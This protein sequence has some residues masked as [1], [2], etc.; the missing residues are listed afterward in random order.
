MGWFDRFFKKNNTTKSAVSPVAEQQILDLSRLLGFDPAQYDEG[1]LS[2]VT[3]FACLKM[4]SEAIGKLPL[5]LQRVSADGGVED[6]VDDPLYR[7]VK[8][9]PN[10][11][12]TP[13]VFWEATENNCNHYG[14]AYAKIRYTEHGAEL[15]PLVSDR[16]RI[17]IPDG[18]T[19]SEAADIMY[20]YTYPETGETVSFCS[21]EILHFKT[22][23]TFGG[24]LGL[25]VR[26]KLRMSLDG[27]KDSQKVLNEM[28][29]NNMAGRAV[30]QYAGTQEINDAL[31]ERYI[32]ELDDFAHGRKK[33]GSTFIPIPYG[34]TVTPLNL[35]L[36]DE[37][38]LEL[39][40]YTAL[41]I[42]S[43]FG[44]K[45]NQLND[46]DRASYAT[47]EAQQLA[48]YVETMLS[49]LKQYEEE[50]NYKLL[51]DA[52]AAQG[53]RFKFNVAAVLRGDTKGQVESLCHGIANG[54]YTPNEARRMLDLPSVSGG[55]RI[56]FNGS[57]IPVELA[58]KQYVDAVGEA[59]GEV[60]KKAVKCLEKVA[61]S[62]IM[63]LKGWVTIDGNHVFIDDGS[64]GSGESGGGT[65]ND[66]G[67]RN[68]AITDDAIS[69]VPAADVFGD[70]DKDA[71]YQQAN[72]DLLTEAKKYPVGTE[73]SRIYDENMNP[74]VIRDKN[75]NVVK[76]YGYT[77]GEIGSVKIDDYEKPYHAFH[78]HPSGETLSPDDLL[79]FSEQSSMLSLTAIGNNSK[80]YIV[81][82]AT[83]TDSVGYFEFLSDKVSEK[84]FFNGAFCYLD[85]K[86]FTFEELPD[87]IREPL[88]KE[89][90]IFTTEC[91][92]GGKQYGINYII[93]GKN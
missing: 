19:L 75:G 20:V 16:M 26:D 6:A 80:L 91:I 10:P 59:V 57:N 28:Y 47:S 1:R 86:G 43:A 49:K 33:S 36:A 69:K 3:Y 73:V 53:Y 93:S 67:Q 23:T 76:E 66:S 24:L 15:Y 83:N 82:R 87:T 72:K 84:R 71:R 41:Q 4:L 13:S 58:G 79:R 11:F 89:I 45:P 31:S 77:V 81:S 9:R 56:Y 5:T 27:A 37:Q 34:T 52:R 30:V 60:G 54:L 51:S 12:M 85:I 38:F 92:D 62:A 74:I 8:V 25:S 44:I 88:K 42:A 22:S 68:I 63:S 90:K 14:N 7:T 39:R 65:L 18:K 21:D 40:K 61:E 17:Y 35:R 70:K 64:G 50:L 2:E 29:K 48:F 55:D 46:Y 78:N 32:K